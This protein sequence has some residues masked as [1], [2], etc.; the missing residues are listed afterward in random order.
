VSECL[1]FQEEVPK[2]RDVRV[3]VIGRTSFAVGIDSQA[4]AVTQV[5]WR[6]TPPE[7]LRHAPIDLP[8]NVC[9]SISRLLDA[10]GL[11]FGAIDLVE[12]DDGTFVFLEINPNG[13][14]GWLQLRTGI[15]LASALA[16]RLI[17]GKSS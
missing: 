17:A 6:H 2:R 5:D 1:I 12:R 14:W 13:Q 15:D 16:E 7:P 11:E 10:F 9:S 3:T 4:H 8:P